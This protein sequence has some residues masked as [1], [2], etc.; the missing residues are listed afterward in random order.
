MQAAAGH[1]SRREFGQAAELYEQVLQTLPG[2]AEALANLGAVNLVGRAYAEAEAYYRRA[3]E[4]TPDSVVAGLGLVKTLLAQHRHDDALDQLQAMNRDGLLSDTDRPEFYKL[5]GIIHAAKEDWDVAINFFSKYQSEQP[6]ELDP[7]LCLRNA[8]TRDNR[9]AE[10]ADLYE[11]LSVKFPNYPEART[12]LIQLRGREGG[13]EA[14]RQSFD[15]MLQAAPH[16]LSLYN[17][18]AVVSLESRKYAYAYLYF[19]R[20]KRHNPDA[21]WKAFP[22]LARLEVFA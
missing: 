22:G 10:L 17:I 8:Y 4:V 5:L 9:V 6:D 14:I 3:L 16:D 20:A 7:Y 13:Y 15:R 21:D 12:H 11:T 19:L 1:F 18:M 2:H